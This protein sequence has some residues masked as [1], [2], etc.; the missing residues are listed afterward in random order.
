MR[1]GAVIAYQ[2]LEA[3][4]RGLWRAFKGRAIR[5]SSA[6]AAFCCGEHRKAHAPRA[7]RALAPILVLYSL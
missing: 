6:A 5:A 2:G 3:V 1:F 4:V 7:A